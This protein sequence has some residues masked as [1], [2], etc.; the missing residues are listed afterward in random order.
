VLVLT[1]VLGF[2]H[3]TALKAQPMT[4]TANFDS[5]FLGRCHERIATFN[6][7]LDCQLYLEAFYRALDVPSEGAVDYTEFMAMSN[8]AGQKD[9][10]LLWSGDLI[11][12]QELA[13]SGRFKNLE[14]TFTGGI[15]N[16]LVWCVNPQG[17]SCP[18]WD[19]AFA[20]K[21]FWGNASYHFATQ[22]EG[23]ATVFLLAKEGG[24]YRNSSIFS[25]IEVPNLNPNQISS[26]QIWVKTSNVTLEAC[27]LGSVATLYRDLVHR[28]IRNITCFNNPTTIDWLSCVNDP[29]DIFCQNAEQPECSEDVT[30]YWVAIFVPSGILLIALVICSVKLWL[31]D[32]RTR[33]LGGLEVTATK[34]TG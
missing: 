21:M 4:A 33:V 7:E 22:T 34:R 32:T 27:G 19:S 26:F 11:F 5:I 25:Q 31:R 29:E 24:A 23:S 18:I 15:L 20:M 13:I 14:T 12:A 2:L 8:F 1:N 28:Q 9:H 3:K 16:G 30:D 6:L 10:N 17:M